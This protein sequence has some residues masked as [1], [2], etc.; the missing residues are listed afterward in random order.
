MEY[1]KCVVC[2]K[3]VPLSE[4][5]IV[6]SPGCYFQWL[7]RIRVKSKKL[8]RA[9][10]TVCA[11]RKMPNGKPAAVACR[12]ITPEACASCGWNPKVERKRIRNAKKS[13]V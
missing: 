8:N 10:V 9:G 11:L 12:D 7:D 5:V 3:P 6:C 1:M 13:K 2:G 4:E